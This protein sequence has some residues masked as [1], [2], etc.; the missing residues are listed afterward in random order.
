[1]KSALLMLEKYLRLWMFLVM[2]S[3]FQVMTLKVL[4]LKE[5]EASTSTVDLSGTG[6]LKAGL[7]K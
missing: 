1:M 4:L 2:P 3:M 6:S 7:Q 5:M